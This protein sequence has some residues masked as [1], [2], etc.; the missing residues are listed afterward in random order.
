[1]RP[2]ILLLLDLLAVIGAAIAALLLRD[3]LEFS[4]QRLEDLLPY[5][6]FSAVAAAGCP[7]YRRNEPRLL[8]LQHIQ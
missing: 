1:M 7:A 6:F 2:I 3:N 4:L 8:A 5:I